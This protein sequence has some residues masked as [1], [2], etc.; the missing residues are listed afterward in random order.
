MEERHSAPIPECSPMRSR[1]HH[2]NNRVRG[3]RCSA[4]WGDSIPSGSNWSLTGLNLPTG[5]NIYIRARGYYR[6]G[7]EN[8][9]E[10]IQES[11][12]NASLPLVPMQVVSRKTHG[13]AGNFD[14]DLPLNGPPGIEC[15]SGGATND[16]QMVVTL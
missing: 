8:A 15:R 10:S 1:S 11:V 9:S 7:Y 3:C 4:R 6:G 13:G 16:Y 2:D 5:Q 12:R 14:V